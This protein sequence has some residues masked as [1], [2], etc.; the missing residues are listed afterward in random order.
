MLRGAPLPGAYCY[1]C[2]RSLLFPCSTGAKSPDIAVATA[3][4]HTLSCRLPIPLADAESQ[5]V[6]QPAVPVPVGPVTGD[7]AVVTGI[8]PVTGPA[9]IADGSSANTHDASV[10]LTLTPTTK[11]HQAG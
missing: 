2:N 1:S 3:Q 4:Q 6:A 5:P 9:A 8:L 10:A 7:A 11:N